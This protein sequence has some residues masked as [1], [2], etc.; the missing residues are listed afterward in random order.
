MRFFFVILIFILGCG[1]NEQQTVTQS[2]SEMPSSDTPAV[3]DTVVHEIRSF[4][5]ALDLFIELDYTPESWQNGIR[6][7]PRLTWVRVPDR[8]RSKT[9]KEIEVKLK[10]QIFFRV[11]APLALQSNEEIAAERDRLLEL[12]KSQLPDISSKDRQWLVK[13]GS[14]YR[15]PEEEVSEIWLAE[16]VKRVD[17]LPLSLVL[18]QSAGESGWG[19]SRFAAEGNALFGQWAWGKDAMKPKEQ[20]EGMGNYGLRTFDTPLE[21]MKAYMLN[22]N[23]HPAY[24]E[25]RDKRA[26][27][28]ARGEQIDGIKL[29]EALTKYS[30]RGEEYVK[31]LQS[32]IQVNHLLQADEAFLS[33]GPVVLV[34]PVE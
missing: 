33:N 2:S 10:K 4:Q 16:L 26:I 5:D 11:L 25:L 23:S 29:S 22:L 34:F 8:W 12:Q 19:T 30:E 28:S 21:S 17:D 9:T 7:I 32:I 1:K 13:L 6:E 15:M 20:R 14:K 18:A 31:T 24:A 27:L 3:Q